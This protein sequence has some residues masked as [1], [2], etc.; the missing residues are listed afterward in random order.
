MA[1]DKQTF[2]AMQV[3]HI[4][5]FIS[6]IRS[7]KRPS[8]DVE[9]GHI[10]AALCHMANISYR[11]GD[12]KLAFDSGNETFGGDNEANRYLKRTYRE[13]WVIPENV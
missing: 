7:R 11:V 9:D 10:S 5:D 13:P 6:C 1:S 3:A 8:A 2:A 4:D 12:R